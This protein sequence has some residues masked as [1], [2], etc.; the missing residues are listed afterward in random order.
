M[1]RGKKITISKK[2]KR[3]AKRAGVAV[4]SRGRLEKP[5]VIA[6]ADTM[7]QA[8]RKKVSIPQVV[9]VRQLAELIDQPTTAVITKL[10]Q[11][12]VQVSINDSVDFDTAAIIADEFNF[13]A[14][15]E[16]EVDRLSAYDTPGK[17]SKKL[18]SRPPVVTVMGHVDHGKTKLLDAIRST[19]IIE[20]ESGGIT[21]HIGAYRASVKVKDGKKSVT[22]Q[23]TFIDTPGH[24]AFSAMR[25][26]GA[27]VTDM[28][29]L[30]V[31]ADD[32]V[33]PQTLE[34]ITHARAAGVPIIVAIN[35]IDKPEAD[36]EKVKRQLSE[37]NL[38]PEEWGGKTPM[39][40]VS[41]KAATNIDKLLE[42]VILTADLNELKTDA[43]LPGRGIIIESK[44][45]PG[46]GPVATIL[47]QDGTLRSGDIMIA[48]E[49][50][51]KIRTME[52]G[53]GARVK[54]AGAATPVLVS[55]FKVM[56]EVGAKILAVEDEKMARET[57]AGWQKSATTRSIIAKKLSVG[58]LEPTQ[59]LNIVV[60]ADV[61]GSLT[62]IKD[63]LADIPQEDIKVKILE[64]AIGP[65]TESDVNMA[66]SSAAIILAFRVHVSPP[67]KRLA[68]TASVRIAR[69]EVIY[70]LVDDVVAILQTMLKPEIVK[71]EIGTLKV[72]K[73]FRRLPEGG[74]V[75]GLITKGFLR[76]G[77]SFVARR[78]ETE[79]GE[80]KINSIKIGPDRID[81][82]EQNSECGI[83][84]EGSFKFKPDDVISAY[85]TQEIVKTIKV[86][87]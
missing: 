43:G 54:T 83:E 31:A 78:G 15:G 58:A 70:D 40:P 5:K 26:H 9:P 86:R 22:R 28:V 30:V 57:V 4:D 50:V 69:Y 32:G 55:G 20:G 18:S 81:R 23:V 85:Q 35:K 46:L 12:G 16:K 72:I 71:T 82:A 38:I 79:L 41:A 51:A 56:P 47:V 6:P 7:A 29:I 25:A 39:V 80:G 49:Q 75:G 60:K 1:A 44:V 62:A 33:K 53:S 52:D 34:A 36:I 45:K 2:I 87:K 21:Q 65:I 64:A 14:V 48:G 84:Y 19:N 27:N 74:I 61:Q 76:P 67:V 11:S 68:D 17:G 77:A 10:F 59:Q 66:A 24:E 37:H 13:E 8:E 42:I 73:V 3:V 63:T